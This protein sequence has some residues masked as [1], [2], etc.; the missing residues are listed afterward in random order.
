VIEKQNQ[1]WANC[2]AGKF[3]KRVGVTIIAVEVSEEEKC[4]GWYTGNLLDKRGQDVR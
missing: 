2:Y 1:Q 3:K 4:P